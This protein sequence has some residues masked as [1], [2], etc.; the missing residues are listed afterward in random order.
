MALVQNEMSTGLLINFLVQTDC[1]QNEL[2]P[3][4]DV[5]PFEEL[6][7]VSFKHENNCLVETNCVDTHPQEYT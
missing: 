4:K 2:T 6:V 7:V 5:S 1:V 3:G